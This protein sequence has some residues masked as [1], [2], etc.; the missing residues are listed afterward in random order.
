MALA[1]ATVLCAVALG[2][3]SAGVSLA[4]NAA[5]A[6]REVAFDPR[7]VTVNVGDTV[8]WT[9]FDG[10][11]HTATADDGSWTT[12]LFSTGSQSLT[13]TVAGAFP[14][15]CQAHPTI[16]RGTLTVLGPTPPPTTPP[17]TT[18]PPT[19]PP[20]TTPPP[21]PTTPPPPPA[22]TAPPV[23]TPSPTPV[24]TTAP[25][26][27]TPTEAPSP[28]AAA[29]A[30]PI[31]TPS[32]VAQA[33]STASPTPS[34]TIASQSGEGPGPALALGA[35]GAGIALVGIALALMRRR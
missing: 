22:P 4:A 11:P 15:H 7:S 13:F 34:A 14:Y 28:T 35:L 29:T 32:I 1:A 10:I 3:A 33:T 25:P 6:M 30:T 20:P 19:T 18:P 23:R 2:L 16:M 8:T 12:P 27:P 24:T 26:S 21:A 31:A 5:V 17:P 9:N